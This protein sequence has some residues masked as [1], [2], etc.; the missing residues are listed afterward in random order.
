MRIRS[1]TFERE[2]VEEFIGAAWEL[3]RGNPGWIPPIKE[4]IAAQL[5]ERNP[6]FAHGR[7]QS[8]LAQRDGRS[9]GR[10]SAM[11]D[12]RLSPGG[13]DEFGSSRAPTG[14]RPASATP[15]PIWRR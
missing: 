11:I 15:T 7:M 13:R 1:F 2:E 8:F 5:S 6:F 9:V 12:E 4:G 3:R 14:G 10:C